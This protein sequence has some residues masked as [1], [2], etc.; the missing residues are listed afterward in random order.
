MDNY[1]SVLMFITGFAIVSLAS[2]QVGL[3]FEWANL[4]LISGF[5][6]TGILVGPFVLKLI[7]TEAIG[8]LNFVDEVSLSFIAFAAGSELRL[9]EIRSRLKSITCVT[10]CMIISTFTIGGATFYYLINFIP[11]LA[12][13]PT[14][15]RIAASILAG[16]ILVARSPSSAIA[17]VNEMRAKGPFT[18]TVLSV[19]VIMDVAVIVLFAINSE[20]ANALLTSINIKIDF[21]ALLFV[22][23]LLS[24]ILGWL[25]GKFIKLT[26]SCRLNSE[27]K[28]GIILLSGYGAFILSTGLRNVSQ[29][30]LSNELLI[31]P[32]L[33]CM[34]GSFIVTNWSQYRDEFLKI[35]HDIGPAVYIAFFTLTGASLALDILARTWPIALA[36]F[37]VR[38]FAIFIGS[39]SGGKI[40]GDPI[41]NNVVSWMAYVTQAG[42]GLGLAK[43]VA[44]EF[45][46][47]GNVFATTIISVIVLNQII[48]PPLFKWVINFV[49][50]AHQRGKAEFEGLR[51]VIIFGVDDQAFAVARQL[52]VHGWKVKLACMENRYI[53]GMGAGQ[54]DMQI[55]RIPQIDLDELKRIDAAHADAIVVMLT[56]E[57]SYQICEIFYENYGTENMVVRLNNLANLERFHR[58][59]VMTVDPGTATI[60]LIEQ[61]VRSPSAASLLLDMESEKHMVD[62]EVHN[63]HV[64]GLALR[65]LH[66]PFDTLILSVNRNGHAIV[67]HGY[68][69]LEVGDKVTIVG[70][71]ESLEAV[72]LKLG[73]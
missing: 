61:F 33:I 67:S 6:F 12:T 22:E 1:F 23:L 29:E 62:L 43:K 4:P 44:V 71:Q 2:K 34:I 28:A 20:I 60:S 35:L 31:E 46:D 21:A 32:L 24:L 59:G 10:T 56:D 15:S 41:R 72:N 52:E 73:I 64:H 49:K 11:F 19:T 9:K 25:L 51:N 65:D 66:L 13:M 40:A 26:L 42:V 5:L 55:C 16:A 69:R 27:V 54:T 18:Q 48:G 58:L 63:P 30:H 39:M 7:P 70:S 38:L 53:T 17:I 36:L 47:F 8:K 37:F 50:E 57:K 3:Y 45:P 14:S 68:T